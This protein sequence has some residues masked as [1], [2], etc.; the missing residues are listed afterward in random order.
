MSDL[1]IASTSRTVSK[2]WR[3]TSDMRFTDDIYISHAAAVEN[4]DL[5]PF[6]RVIALPVLQKKET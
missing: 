1:N 5:V 6:H 3:Y 2:D 4:R